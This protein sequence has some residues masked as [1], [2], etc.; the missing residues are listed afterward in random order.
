MGAEAIF[1]RLVKLER[2][3]RVA[4]LILMLLAVDKQATAQS[5][6]FEAWLTQLRQEAAAEVS[7]RPRWIGPWTGWS[8]SPR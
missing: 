8:R 2:L 1:A 4:L 5:A 6:S 7:A 3:G